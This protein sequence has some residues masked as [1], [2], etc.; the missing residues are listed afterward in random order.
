MKNVTNSNITHLRKKN[1]TMWTADI[2]FYVLFVIREA[3]I[4]F[5]HIIFMAHVMLRF[6]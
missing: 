5:E 2:E 4:A 6:L 3:V 1:N